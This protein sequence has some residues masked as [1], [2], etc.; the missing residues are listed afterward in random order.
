MEAAELE[1][2]F[3]DDRLPEELRRSVV[4]SELA[5]HVAEQTAVRFWRSMSESL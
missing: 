5:L 1:R 4:C 2:R 3:A